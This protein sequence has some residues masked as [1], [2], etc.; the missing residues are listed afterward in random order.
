MLH[1]SKAVE[2]CSA[3]QSVCDK[4][5][6][7]AVQSA[8]NKMQATLPAACGCVAWVEAT[9]VG[10]YGQTKVKGLTITNSRQRSGDKT[11]FVSRA[12]LHRAAVRGSLFSG[13]SSLL[14][15]C[16]DVASPSSTRQAQS[17]ASPV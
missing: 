5:R 17:M 3:V 2:K 12:S 6:W 10:C 7:L 13:L 11:M 16:F 14:Y 15:A 1:V 9:V 4:L 8:C